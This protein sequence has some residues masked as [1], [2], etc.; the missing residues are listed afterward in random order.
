MGSAGRRQQDGFEASCGQGYQGYQ[1]QKQRRQQGPAAGRSLQCNEQRAGQ[2]EGRTPTLS[3]QEGLASWP[4]DE[5]AAPASSA[6]ARPHTSQ[7]ALYISTRASKQRFKAAERS[8]GCV[9]V[10]RAWLVAQD[11]E[12]ASQ[13]SMI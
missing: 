2:S 9:H 7:R 5:T 4:S 6:Q 10:V 13:K 1:G 11:A 8:K 12:C 3:M